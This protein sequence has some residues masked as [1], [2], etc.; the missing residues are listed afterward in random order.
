MQPI[1][2][3]NGILERRKE[4][5]RKRRDKEKERENKRLWR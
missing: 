2:Y 5:G 3:G 1:L 4:E